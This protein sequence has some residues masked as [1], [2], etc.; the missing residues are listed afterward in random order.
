MDEGGEGIQRIYRR[1][2]SPEARRAKA[3]IWKRL[4]ESFFQR[5]VGASD[6]VLDLGCGF[7]EF[8]NCLRCGRKIGVDMNPDSP[9]YLA[10]DVEFHPTSVCGLDFLAD[11]SVNFVFTSNVMEHL[12]SK[13]AVEQMLREVRRVLKPGGQ[14][15][16]MGPNLR[17]LPGTY[18]DFWDHLVPISDRSLVDALETMG[19]QTV[20]RIGRFLPYTTCASLPQ[21]PWLVG[22][23]LKLRFL[24]PLFGKQFLV[25]AHKAEG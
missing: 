8:L 1:R 19:F 17:C 3:A 18:W 16:A 6:V 24:W 20:D 13:L 23:Y 12:P 21:R 9:D 15:V 10:G 4:V 25:R 22:V 5:W 7:G 2:F 14:F 11:G